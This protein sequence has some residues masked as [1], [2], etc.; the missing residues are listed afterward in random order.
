[1]V[2]YFFRAKQ[3]L[4]FE[5]FSPSDDMKSFSKKNL[6]INKRLRSIH[7]LDKDKII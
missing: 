6:T 1:M 5:Q 7:I 4:I 3:V 2:E